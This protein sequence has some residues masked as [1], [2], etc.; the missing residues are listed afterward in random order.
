MSCTETDGESRFKVI[1]T[2]DYP[3]LPKYFLDHV[4]LSLTGIGPHTE[5]D[6]GY[7]YV[8]L[9]YAIHNL[10][11]VLIQLD[12]DCPLEMT[13]FVRSIVPDFAPVIVKIKKSMGVEEYLKK[14]DGK[15][16]VS[17]YVM[18]VLQ[19]IEPNIGRTRRGMGNI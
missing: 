18:D 7:F 5:Q 3:H 15:Y 11:P 4:S 19:P 2:G 6:H 16:Y 14:S 10:T 8:E 13:T 17:V 9:G 1:T 12:Q